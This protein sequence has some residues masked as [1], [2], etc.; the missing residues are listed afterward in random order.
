MRVEAHDLRGGG[1]GAMADLHLHDSP[2]GRAIDEPVH[3][4]GD[5]PPPQQRLARTDHDGA[6]LGTDG[7]DEHRLGEAARQSAPLPN[8]EAGVPGVLAD[9][10]AVG[11]HDRAARQR[12]GIV[13]QALSNDPRVVAIGNEADVLRF[14][15]LGHDQPERTRHVARLG[16]G[17]VPDREEHARDHGAVDPPQE[18]GLV[19]GLVEPAVQLPVDD[20]RVVPRRDV[21]R[22][23][24]VGLAQQ[25]TELGER[26]APHAGNRCA[27][28]GVLAHEV[29]HHVVTERRLQVE[30]VVRDAQRFADPARIVDRVERTAR[31]VGDV[32]AVAEQLHGRAHHLE[33]LGMQQRGGDRGV[34]AA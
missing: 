2:D 27:P 30:H 32:V 16:L 12:G 10:P 9:D 22:I 24:G 21:R 26:I 20:A 29:V 14:D 34:D 23:D 11:E 33:P 7:H 17:L 28:G 19:L 3:V 13:A 1:G 18:V 6:R 4:A 5:H 31:L 8:G 25:V 15:L